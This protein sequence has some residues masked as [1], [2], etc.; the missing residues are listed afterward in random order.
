MTAHIN[1]IT[2]SLLQNERNAQDLA[3]E[4]GDEWSDRGGARGETPI[5]PMSC[6]ASST[7]LDGYT[8]TTRRVIVN[9]EDIDRRVNMIVHQERQIMDTMKQQDARCKEMLSMIRDSRDVSQ[10]VRAASEEMLQGI[11]RRSPGGRI[12]KRL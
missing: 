8:G 1:S 2:E 7:P 5:Y 3:S 12:W 10:N 11:R 4:R 6:N 9:F